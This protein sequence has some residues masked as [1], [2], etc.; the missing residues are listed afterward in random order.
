MNIGT[1]TAGKT[2]LLAVKNLT[3]YYHTKPFFGHSKVIKA[4]DGVSFELQA[5]KTMGL[6]G[7]SGCGKSTVGKTILNLD[8][9]TSGSI[10]FDGQ[11]ITHLNRDELRK[12]RRNLQLIF[13]D[14]Y[15]SLNARMKVA[16]ILAEPFKIHRLYRGAELR[17]Q[18]EQLLDLVGLPPSSAQKYPHEF[19]GGQRQRIVIARAIALRPRFVVCD[20]P[21]S[22]LDVSVQSQIINLFSSLQKELGLTYLFISHDLSVVRYVSDEVGV[23]YLGKLVE[24]GQVDR[25]YS[26][27]LHPY[28]QALMSSIPVPH[29]RLQR[30]REKI[31]LAGDLPSPLNPPQGCHFHT[32]CNFCEE[33][34]RQEEPR[35][36]E[37]EPRHWVACHLVKSK[38]V[39]SKTEGR[40]A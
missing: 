31:I 35:W 28:T 7:E 27:A 6:V 4:V 14:P 5:G 16:E 3:K 38:T 22:A 30:S 40:E 15:S 24:L 13:Q 26:N 2:P 17:A 8:R 39:K 20:E 19:S 11:E 34:C 32:R 29:P 18:V 36:R 21:V 9:L 25:I 23:M 12:T 1:E 10:V 33:Q 37:I